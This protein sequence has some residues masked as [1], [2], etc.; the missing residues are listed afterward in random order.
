MAS[1]QYNV[2]G[3]TDW[4]P[5]AATFNSSV[6]LGKLVILS[7]PVSSP[8]VLTSELPGDFRNKLICMMSLEL[9]LAHSKYSINFSYH[10]YYQVFHS[11]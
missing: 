11:Y 10:H 2:V 5:N 1:V 9:A 6:L 3:Y 4:Y 8:V 7:M